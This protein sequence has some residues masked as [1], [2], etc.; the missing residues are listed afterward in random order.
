MNYLNEKSKAQQLTAESFPALNN[1][2]STDSTSIQLLGAHS[3]SKLP[4][5]EQPNPVKVNV[6]RREVPV[7]TTFSLPAP[8]SIG[9]VRENP[10][11]QQL[12]GKKSARGGQQQQQKQQ[13]PQQRGSGTPTQ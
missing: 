8:P 9:G 2:V 5:P 7:A 12:A 10:V 1:A 4:A 11:L 6:L 13:Q 3:V